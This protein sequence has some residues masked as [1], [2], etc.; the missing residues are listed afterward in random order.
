MTDYLGVAVELPEFAGEPPL[1]VAAVIPPVINP[2][3][4]RNRELPAAVVDA[5]LRR[6]GIRTDL[7]LV[8]QVSPFDRWDDP[9][10]AVTTY[11]KAATVVRDLQWALVWTPDFSQGPGDEPEEGEEPGRQ[12]RGS[13]RPLRA[14]LV[15]A[16]GRL[17]VVAGAFPHGPASGDQALG[18]AVPGVR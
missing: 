3:V 7:P 15:A 18:E 16:Q 12:L 17:P 9:Q 6:L 2:Q 1:D 10:W 14:E 13:L 11:Q 8:V 5:A 4:E